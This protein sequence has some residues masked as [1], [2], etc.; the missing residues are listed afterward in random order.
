MRIVSLLLWIAAVQSF[1]PLVLPLKSARSSDRLHV[2]SDV[3]DRPVLEVVNPRKSGLALQLDDGTRKSHSV[4]ENSAFV[5]GFFKGL[6]TKESFG[7]LVTSLY[8]I[9]ET[10]EA[11]LE[12]STDPGVR[13]LDYPLLRRVASLE[14]DMEYFF[15]SS[16]RSTARRSA[17]TIKYC[18]HLRKISAEAPYLIVAHQYTRYLGDLFVS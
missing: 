16:W 7:S 10:Q 5:S 2:V 15:G 18:D 4:A 8:F 9:Y 1:K 6:S 14:Q 13:A 3:A 12:K 17:G 11:V